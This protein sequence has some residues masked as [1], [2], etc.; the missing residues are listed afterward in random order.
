MINF[1]LGYHENPRDDKFDPPGSQTINKRT[2][3]PTIA[4]Y[5]KSTRSTRLLK[6]CATT[7]TSC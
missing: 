6:R 4:R 5:L 1:V 7:G 2:V 3:K